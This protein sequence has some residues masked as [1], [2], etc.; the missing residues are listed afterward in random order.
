MN[1]NI[2]GNA[3]RLTN[4]TIN[5][6]DKIIEFEKS[7]N[8]FVNS[9]SKEKHVTLL[10]DADC[11]HLSMRRLNN[12]KL[13]GHMLVFGLEGGNS[14]LELRRITINEKGIGFG[15]ES[16][17]LLKKLCF[18]ELKFHRLWL[19][20]YDDNSRAIYLYESE[21]FIKEGLLR[22]K[23]KINNGYRSQ[24]IYSILENEYNGSF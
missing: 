16:L 2:I 22:D 5:D 18:E 11:I 23:F 19:D 6:L 14:S 9:Y 21:G 20:V 1:V 13:V 7:N 24:R 3:I 12:D 15:R 8:N 4:S 17:K 10:D